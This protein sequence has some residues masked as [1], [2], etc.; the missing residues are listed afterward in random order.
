MR[1]AGIVEVGG[2]QMIELP[3]PRQLTPDE[4]LIEVKAAGVGNWDE[5]VRTGG[6]N[7]GSRPPM[8]LGVEASGV[9]TALGNDLTDWSVGDEVMTHPVPL[10]DQGAW[11]EQLI[12]GGHLLASKPELVSWEVAAT[13]PVPALTASK[14]L[15]EAIGPHADDDRLLVHGAG[16]VTGGLVVQLARLRGISVIATAGP[17][18]VDALTR[19]GVDAVLDYHDNRWPEVVRELTE[20]AGVTAAVNAAR[21]QERR[22][23]S[24][25]ADG[26]RLATITGS[27]PERERGVVIADVY[28]HA[29]GEQLRQL[30]AMLGRHELGLSIGA[31]YELARASD[32]L[33]LATGG[34][35][36][37]AVALIT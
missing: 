1:A 37:G 25:V 12:V 33:E 18:S 2:V 16:G 8:A 13:F 34:A 10:R 5:F 28:V 21:G 30:A 22:A 20:G 15:D 29:D 32:A 9:I 24:T 36:G 17:R 35:A 11:S 3:K 6:W 31:V 26:G 7:V 19:L 4:A 23:L 14:A 27:P